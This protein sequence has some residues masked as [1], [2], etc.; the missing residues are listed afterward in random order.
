MEISVWRVR[1]P[2]LSQLFDDSK[3]LVALERSR[4]FTPYSVW[5]GKPG[6]FNPDGE[7]RWIEAIGLY[8]AHLLFIEHNQLGQMVNVGA[9]LAADRMVSPLSAMTEDHLLT[10]SYGL[11]Y[12]QMKQGLPLTGIGFNE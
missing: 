11:L 2:E 3:I 8:A 4:L 12:R 9:N 1:Y 5:V 7:G 10:T 6:E